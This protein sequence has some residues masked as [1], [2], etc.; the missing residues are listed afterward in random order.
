MNLIE[1]VL[2]KINET[3]ADDIVEALTYIYDEPLDRDS[4]SAY[5]QFIQDAV[6]IIDMDTE[7]NMQGDV[8]ANLSKYIPNMIKA[9]ENCNAHVDADIMRKIYKISLALELEQDEN[10]YDEHFATAYELYDKMYHNNGY[11]LWD[12][13]LIPYIEQER[14]IYLQTS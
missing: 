11:Y 6:F 9:L 8:I 1:R 2:D 14:K 10:K 5:P 12:D 3:S 4:L 13:Y 7:L